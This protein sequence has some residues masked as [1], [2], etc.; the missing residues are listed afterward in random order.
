ML[1]LI[2]IFGEKRTYTA[3]NTQNNHK[4]NKK[5]LINEIQSPKIKKLKKAEERC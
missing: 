1:I 5:F 2:I 4:E 3:Y